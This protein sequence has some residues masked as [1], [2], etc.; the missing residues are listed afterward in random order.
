M[1]CMTGATVPT[2][3]TTSAR[4]SSA[5]S[6]V[7]TTRTATPR[8]TTRWCGWSRTGRCVTRWSTGRAIALPVDQRVAQR[9]VLDQ[10]HQRVID[11]GVAVRVV[12][13]HNLADDARALVVAAVGT[14]A[15]VI[16]RVDDPAVHGLH[17]VAHVR[18][19]A[20]DDD[21]HRIVDVAALHL[22][23]DVD[24]LDAVGLNDRRLLSHAFILRSVWR[25]TRGLGSSSSLTSPCTFGAAS[26]SVAAL[27]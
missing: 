14:V 27:P 4:A 11:R 13:T 16:H 6:W 2:A 12:L 10:P 18:K 25:K 1:R 23:V 20:T 22:Q 7:S 24:R 26:S 9:P 8:S 3:A 15:P 17:A 21:R 5:R 19:R